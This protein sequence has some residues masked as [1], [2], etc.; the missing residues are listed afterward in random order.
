MS[1]NTFKIGLG[2][3]DMIE[4]ILKSMTEE[5]KAEKFDDLM[6][7]HTTIEEIIEDYK[8]DLA[9]FYEILETQE[10]LSNDLKSDFNKKWR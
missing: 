7:G 2:E 3:G 4:E 5:E 10:S 8:S 9:S 6:K 1:S